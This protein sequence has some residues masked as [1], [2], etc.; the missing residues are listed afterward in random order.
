ML[1]RARN[2][3]AFVAQLLERFGARANERLEQLA[4]CVEGGSAS[5]VAE[6]VHGLLGAARHLSAAGLTNACQLMELAARAGDLRSA[7]GFIVDIRSELDR[8]INYVPRAV[9]L[10]RAGTVSPQA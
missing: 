1:G 2:D 10:L 8:C 4:R 3:T 9:G 6:E 5:V 7:A